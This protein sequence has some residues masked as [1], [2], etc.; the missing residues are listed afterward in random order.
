MTLQ[1]VKTESVT[2]L[3]NG[4]G[5]TLD[6][7]EARVTITSDNKVSESN[8]QVYSKTN[9]YVGSFNYNRSGGVNVN[10]SNADYTAMDAADEVLA[11]IRAVES[12]ISI[13]TLNV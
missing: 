5:D 2:K 12:Q 13:E 11:Y 9:A 3:I 4:T 6:I 8:G 1:E 10:I 7:K